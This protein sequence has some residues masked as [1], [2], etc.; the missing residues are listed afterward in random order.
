MRHSLFSCFRF[1]QVLPLQRICLCERCT[2]AVD[3]CEL[4]PLS[5]RLHWFMV[6]VGT[7]IHQAERA[8][9]TASSRIFRAA[10]TSLLCSWPQFG[11]VH[12]RTDRSFAFLK[13]VSHS[14]H[15]WLDGNHLDTLMRCFPARTTPV[16]RGDITIQIQTHTS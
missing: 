7:S 1:L 11:H 12:S 2:H 16:V 3:R 5:Q 15:S 13:I 4:S 8:I 6:I 14:W 10:L 9:L